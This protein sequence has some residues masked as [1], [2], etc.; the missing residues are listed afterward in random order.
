M[1][2]TATLSLKK[3]E[4]HFG[5]QDQLSLEGYYS[6]FDIIHKTKTEFI[7]QHSGRWGAKAKNIYDVAASY[8]TQIMLL[9]RKNKITQS[10]EK[11]M[12]LLSVDA[13]LTS[14]YS[15]SSPTI[16]PK[17][18]P[19]W[20]TLFAEN[21]SEYCQTSAPEANDSPVSYLSWLY[22]QALSYEKQMGENDIISLST[23]RPDL[24]ELML[25]N[26]AVNQVVPSLQLVN[27]ILE[28]SVT[29][30]VSM[31]NSKSTVSEVLATT[32]Y[33]T[34]LPYHY[35]HQQALLSLKDSDES[36]QAVI[37]KADTTWPYF[38]KENLI[39]GNAEN[40]LLLGSDLAPEQL[41]IITEKANIN[42][43]FY[44]ENFGV[45][46][47]NYSILKD[48]AILCHQLNIT[49]QQLEKVISCTEGGSSVV[50]SKNYPDG[51]P[52]PVEYGA[53]YINQN[54]S[55]TVEIIKDAGYDT[56][57]NSTSMVLT[58]TTIITGK[59]GDGINVDATK[60]AE[61][62]ITDDFSVKNNSSADFCLTFWCKLPADV[63]DGATIVTNK[64]GEYTGNAKGISL[65]VSNENNQV[66]F[67]LGIN[68]G[69]KSL[70]VSA[71]IVVDTWIFFCI[72]QD[73]TGKKLTCYYSI[74]NIDMNNSS[75]DCS[76][77]SSTALSD[78]YWGFNS[79]KGNQ[80]YK[81]Y[82]GQAGIMSFDDI[83]V[84]NR[85]LTDDEINL[86]ITSNFPA[87][88]YTNM[89]HYYPLE[90]YHLNNLSDSRLNNIQQMVRL[91][92][93]TDLPYD[94]IDTLMSTAPVINTEYS[95]MVLK[96]IY[97]RSGKFGDGIRV[98]ATVGAEAYFPD[99]VSVV[100]GD[101]A[102]FSLAFWCKLP[103][104]VKD[105]A[106]IITNKMGEYS[107]N[108]KGIS[109]L[110]KY[111][112]S[113]LQFTLNTS[114][115]S[116]VLSQ[117]VNMPTDAWVFFCLCQDVT[118]KKVYCYYSTDG[119]TLLNVC[120]DYS[121]LSSIALSNTYWGFNSNKDNTHYKSY[122]EQESIID[123]D[124]ITVWN[125]K[126]SES[127]ITKFI[128]SN[129]PAAGYVT[130]IHNFSFE[131]IQNSSEL[132]MDP[133]KLTTF[134]H[135][136]KKY[137]V[138]S[139][140]FSA[141][142]DVISPYAITPDVPFLDQVFNSSSL[143]DEPLKINNT[144]FNYTVLDNHD[145]QIV[146]QICAGLGITHTQFLL[147]ANQVNIAQKMAK[148]TLTCSLPVISALYRLVMVPR[149][150]GLSFAEGLSLLML[151]ENGNAL[152]KLASVPFYTVPNNNGQCNSS[153]LLNT[154]MALSDAAQWLADNNLT[155]TGVL[156]MLQAG[157][158]ILPATTAEI[159]FIAGINQ[160][161]P[162]TLLNENCFSSLPRDIISES[163]YCPNGMNIGSLYNNT[164]YE[165]NSTDKQYAC[166]SDKAN[167]ILNPGSNISSTLGMWCYIK[168]GAS[169]GVPL[170]ASATIESNGNAE[171]GIAITLGDGYKFNISMKDANGESADISSDTAKW[172]KNDTWFYLTLRM[173][174]NGMLCL[175]VYSDD[176]KT[177]TSSTLDYN[178]IGNCN[179]EGN[180]WA[181][182][183]DGS[184]KFYSTHSSKKNHI[185]ISDVTVWQKNISNE[186][187]ESIIQSCRPANETVP[188]GIPFIKSTWMDSLNNLIDHS[189]LV[190]PIATDYQTIS[191]IVHNDLCYGTS[192][193]QLN[194]VSNIIYQ[195][196][197]A[198][199]NIADSALAKAFNI[200]H[201]YPPYLLAWAASSE[202]DLL[203]QSLALN[204]ITTP[205]TIPDEYQQ[206]LYQIARRAGLCN[207]FNLTP[208]MLSTL[209]AHPAWFGVAD[210]T[211]DFNLLYL[212]SR[213][214][215]WMKLADKEDAMLAYLRRVNGTP[216]PTPEQ[217]ASCLALLTDWESDEVLQAAAHADPATGI[218]TTLAH[219]DVVMRLKT[220]CTHT[221]TS[222]ETMLNTGDLTTTSTYQE[223]QSVGES[224]VAAQ[225]NH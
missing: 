109:L 73:V 195:A 6:I 116:T 220:L 2:M 189:G 118:A 199:Q 78:S 123:F 48:P 112:N 108:A 206:Y 43:D 4:E 14:L 24:A 193:S 154:L 219:I 86:F 161:L 214:S 194:E 215:D 208:A 31:I 44:K 216:S 207:T 186:E 111:T 16:S 176:G 100:K 42:A 129:K 223:W 46:C 139:Q 185:F 56:I 79:N 15:N 36:L 200:D 35:P 105:G 12:D 75:I 170:I 164:S 124:D 134:N 8:A 143:F 190:L 197:L 53:K 183:E 89:L 204:G 7:K 132:V 25:D 137:N 30:Y 17:N 212:F 126:L 66:K 107:G 26:D 59:F 94:Q 69:S 119:A 224:L 166:L 68:D 95:S 148:N 202:Y 88:E 80:H 225:S 115:G 127:E 50:V 159:N 90:N 27:E 184:Q 205:D 203:S 32:R 11:S 3:L 51:V 71:D 122:P 163:V 84:W 209:L 180:R 181:I 218:A 222:V 146:K 1:S 9:S 101:S 188:G 145:G 136:Q 155:A 92:R 130:M 210:T 55:N 120:N 128:T 131:N 211:I 81:S 41:S 103:A 196:K 47:N 160:Q 72:A 63:K 133:R 169:L 142:L 28:Q 58:N 191:T 175:D 221:G 114:D 22:N 158:H 135:Y 182:N 13:S 168:N 150:L 213:Y 91:Q 198:Q 21:W 99:D 77:L 121:T 57:S 74:N 144:S 179:V 38:V 153:D 156:S 19:T 62:Y 76:T 54:D 98:D 67:S 93:W 173:P 201:S 52:S 157:N 34:Q 147:L 60:N 37:K 117:S 187:V 49:K 110:V 162:S 83:T 61:A 165:L 171:T 29:P 149:W 167:D 151:V 20:Q 217:A 102:D 104:D 177:M 125:R 97:I 65:L 178:K 45:E 113:I 70:S 18:G 23:R 152:N 106:T 82:P 40:V 33:P 96:N 140:Q 172:N 174:G 138:N 10:F 141:V 192:E 85:L 39:T 87:A 64:T 5:I